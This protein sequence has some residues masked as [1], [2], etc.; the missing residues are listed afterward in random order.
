MVCNPYWSYC[1]FVSCRVW[2]IAIE[3]NFAELSEMDSTLMFAL[4]AS[5]LSVSI[6]ILSNWKF[7]AQKLIYRT[8]TIV[9]KAVTKI[10][11]RTYFVPSEDPDQS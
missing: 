6:L 9:L 4:F 10:V 11:R 3:L 1:L 5:M 2:L 7:H 8:D